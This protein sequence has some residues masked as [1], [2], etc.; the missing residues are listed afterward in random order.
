MASGNFLKFS[1]FV[2]SQ[3]SE[4]ASP[5]SVDRKSKHDIRLIEQVTAILV[6]QLRAT[7]LNLQVDIIMLSKGAQLHRDIAIL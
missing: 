4:V 2:S 3:D 7:H 5:D 1:L 6:L